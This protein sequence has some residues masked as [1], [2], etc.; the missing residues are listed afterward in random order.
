MSGLN[1]PSILTTSFTLEYDRT[2]DGSKVSTAVVEL[3]D[4]VTIRLRIADHFGFMAELDGVERELTLL[5]YPTSGVRHLSDVDPRIER[6]DTWS[7]Q[8]SADFY[9]VIEG[10]NVEPILNN[11]TPFDVL[12]VG[13]GSIYVYPSL[14][15]YLSGAESELEVGDALYIP[16]SVIEVWDVY[17]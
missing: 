17:P 8:W 4:G 13:V 3:L 10:V 1:A 14:R 9:G 12:N 7:T 5:A 6:P 2:F 11:G 15:E 16:A